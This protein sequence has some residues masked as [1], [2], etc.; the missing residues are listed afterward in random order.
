M[1]RKSDWALTWYLCFVLTF[2]T[3][4]FMNKLNNYKDQEICLLQQHISLLELAEEIDKQ[5]R[6][7]YKLKIDLLTE[8]IESK[9]TTRD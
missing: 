1:K 6:L 8:I 3:L 7:I 9:E 2:F 4:L 5:N